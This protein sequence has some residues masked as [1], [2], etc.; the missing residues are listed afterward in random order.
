MPLSPNHYAEDS[1]LKYHPT[2]TL[3]AGLPKALEKDATASNDIPSSHDRDHEL[4]TDGASD[5][6]PEGG[7]T[8]RLVIFG[9]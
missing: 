3:Q 9:S 2:P 6:F 1:C 7:L 5:T 8:A 4:A